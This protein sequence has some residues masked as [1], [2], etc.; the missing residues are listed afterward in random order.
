MNFVYNGYV[1]DNKF[2]EKLT[3]SLND[4]NAFNY[5]KFINK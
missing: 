1:Y 4:I 2:L 3:K 5:N